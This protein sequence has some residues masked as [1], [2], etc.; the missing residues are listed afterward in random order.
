MIRWKFWTILVVIF[1]TGVLLG[2]AGTALY[3]RHVASGIFRGDSQA[4]TR[5][6]M[7]KM[8]SGLDLT[9]Q[10]EIQAEKIIES[11]QVKWMNL[12]RELAPR[13]GKILQE[14]VDELKVILS[15]RQAEEL[16]HLFKEARDHWTL[17]GGVDLQPEG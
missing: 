14:T 12:R 11:G 2:S 17:A 8:S 9:D 4:L 10:Q 3:I 1:I 13:V 16:D 6:I 5:I 7:I 15:P